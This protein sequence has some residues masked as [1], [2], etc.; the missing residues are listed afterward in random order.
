MYG[1]DKLEQLM[2]ESDYVVNALPVTESTFEVINA[3]AIA[4]MKK[5][6]VFVNVGRGKTVDETA[7][8]KGGQIECL[9]QHAWQDIA[10]SQRSSL[11][12]AG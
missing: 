7:L 3:Q 5:S 11:S 12:T 8:I 1:P 9:C 10:I 6:A 2:S 4:K